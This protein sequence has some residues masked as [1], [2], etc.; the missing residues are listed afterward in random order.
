MAKYCKSCWKLNKNPLHSLC[1]LCTSSSGSFGKSSTR[2]KPSALKQQSAS[3]IIRKKIEGKETDVFDKVYEIQQGK[4]LLTWKPVTN[5]WVEC[6]PHIL[7][8]WTYPRLRLQDNNVV[9]VWSWQLHDQVD[10]VIDQLKKEIWSKEL[11]ERIK[12]WEDLR[13]TIRRQYVVMLNNNMFN[14]L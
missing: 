8:K 13:S 2:L 1:I 5:P 11:E 4:C 10:L 6:Y 3:K 12:S 9:L 14:W 7:N